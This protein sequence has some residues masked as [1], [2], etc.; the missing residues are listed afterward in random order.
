MMKLRRM[1]FIVA[2]LLLM[3]ASVVPVVTAYQNLPCFDGEGCPEP[4]NPEPD[5][6]YMVQCTIN[7]VWVWVSIP[8]PLLVT[9]VS[10]FQIDA[11]ND[12]ASLVVSNN[13]TVTRSD[14]MITLSGENGNF[15]PQPGEKSFSWS[16]CIERNG[17]LPELSSVEGELT[18]AQRECMNL[19]TEQ[20]RVDC[21]YVNCP[22]APDFPALTRSEC[23]DSLYILYEEI[24][25]ILNFCLGLPVTVGIVFFATFRTRPQR[26]RRL[27][28]SRSVQR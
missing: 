22:G 19:P 21:L 2:A 18:D 5:E 3:L 15:A 1:Q 25:A 20:E 13:V 23:P 14:D 24:N 4:V 26:K 7:A 6:Y 11:L 12:G 16:E 8:S 10:F 9:S 27:N 28:S 17:S